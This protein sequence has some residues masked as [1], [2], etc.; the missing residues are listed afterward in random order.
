MTFTSFENEEAREQIVSVLVSPKGP[1]P[2]AVGVLTITLP[3]SDYGSFQQAIDKK[4]GSIS[5]LA[6]FAYLRSGSLD[7]ISGSFRD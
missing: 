6:T 7:D 2:L 4:L 5:A 3:S 1:L